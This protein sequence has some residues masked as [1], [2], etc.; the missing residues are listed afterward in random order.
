MGV[1]AC[2]TFSLTI[3]RRVGY[4]LRGCKYLGMDGKVLFAFCD[5]SCQ[6][7]LLSFSELHSKLQHQF[8][9]KRRWCLNSVAAFVGRKFRDPYQPKR[10]G[11][12]EVLGGCR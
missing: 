10:H 6:T 2:L 12:R 11:D 1:I 4:S 3:H 7:L 8:S 5:K 9:S